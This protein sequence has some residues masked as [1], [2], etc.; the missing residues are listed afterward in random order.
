M[1][2]FASQRCEC[3]DVKKN[4]HYAVAL[5]NENYCDSCTVH[6]PLCFINLQSSDL[7]GT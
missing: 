7:A 1:N 3:N 6:Y 5:A 4:L 2:E